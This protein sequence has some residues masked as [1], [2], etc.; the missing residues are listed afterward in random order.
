MFWRGSTPIH[1]RD[2]S[3]FSY[4]KKRETIVCQGLHCCVAG[5]PGPYSE[6]WDAPKTQIQPLQI[7]SPLSPLKSLERQGFFFSD[8]G[9]VCPGLGTYCYGF[10]GLLKGTNSRT[11]TSQNADLPSHIVTDFCRVSIVLETEHSIRRR[12]SSLETTD[13]RR[14]PQRTARTQNCR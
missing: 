9:A 7:P 4:Q 6:Y 5:G 11:Q 10:Q 3:G 13:C 12:R 8:S 14:N 2:T 1:S